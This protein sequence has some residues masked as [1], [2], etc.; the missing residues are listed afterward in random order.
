LQPTVEIDF[1]LDVGLLGLTLDGAL[2]HAEILYSRAF[3]Q[4]FRGFATA[5]RTVCKYGTP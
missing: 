4:G 2:A 3:Y 5:L 1:N